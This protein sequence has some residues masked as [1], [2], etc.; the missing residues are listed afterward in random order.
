MKQ[1]AP[2]FVRKLFLLMPGLLC[3]VPA[4][5][6]SLVN[7]AVSIS[8]AVALSGTYWIVSIL[9]GGVIIGLE[10]YHKRWSLILAVTVGLLIF[11]PRWTVSALYMPDCTF[12]NVQ[13]SQA[14]LAVLIAMLGFRVIKI[15]LAYR[16][17]ARGASG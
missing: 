14:I 3:A 8:N 15:L 4:F 11:H 2:Q 9:L 6:C 7:E 12:I 5:A 16:R 1:F 13:A 10:V 17:T